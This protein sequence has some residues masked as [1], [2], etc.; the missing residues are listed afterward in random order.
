MARSPRLRSGRR[1][2]LTGSS[3]S[4]AHPGL[5]PSV[6]MRCA[7]Q[8]A[9]RGEA[10]AFEALQG[11]AAAAFDST[12]L[13]ALPQPEQRASLMAANNLAVW[14]ALGKGGAPEDKLEAAAIFTRLAALS[15]GPAWVNMGVMLR[16]AGEHQHAERAFSRA[17]SRGC[18]R[19]SAD[20]PRASG[21]GRQMRR[22]PTAPQPRDSPAS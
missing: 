12:E 15:H 21:R 11:A 20:S 18:V 9:E 19:V 10:C 16:E 14:L 7:M 13:D 17:E 5:A 8:L 6:L 3:G 1:V 4:G 2:A 22:L